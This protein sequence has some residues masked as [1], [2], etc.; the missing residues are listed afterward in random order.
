VISVSENETIAVLP[1][2][3]YVEEAFF[4][5]ILQ[6]KDLLNEEEATLGLIG[7]KPTYPSAKYGYIFPQDFKSKKVSY[8]IEKPSEEEAEIWIQKGAVWNAGVFGY[9]LHTILDIVKN[10]N[11]PVDYRKLMTRYDELPKNSFDYEFVEKQKNITFLRYDG[12]WKDLGTWNTLT[13]E[14]GTEIVGRAQ[15]IDGKNTHVVNELELPVAVI[16][17]QD[18]VVAAGFEGVL[19]TSKKAS[20]R[21][22]EINNEYFESIRFIEEDWGV[23]HTLHE[24]GACCTTHY[25]MRDNQKLDFELGINQKLIRLSGEGTVAQNGK[26]YSVTGHDKFHFVVV[27][28]G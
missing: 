5:T 16:G 10:Q 13:E 25:E 28:E 24:S 22:K 7:I 18:I 19:V 20:T 4:Q 17:L 8:F 9:R 27:T 12:F 15:I 23:R 6:L 1:V 2:D 21:I 26:K 3:P 14:M 11:L